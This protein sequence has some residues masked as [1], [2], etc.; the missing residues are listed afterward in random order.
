MKKRRWS[1][2]VLPLVLVV[3]FVILWELVISNDDNMDAINEKVEE[4]TGWYPGIDSIAE[5]IL[6][7]PTRILKTLTST[8]R[9][10]RGG[11]EY[12]WRH[13]RSTLYGARPWRSVSGSRPRT[14]GPVR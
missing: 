9:S 10:G 7:R 1:R 8:P 4:L 6:P 3:I 5:T 13:T 2:I 14:R 11:P 12:F